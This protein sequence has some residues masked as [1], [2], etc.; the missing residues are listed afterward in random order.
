M[1]KKVKADRISASEESVF[2]LRSLNFPTEAFREV[3]RLVPVLFFGASAERSIFFVCTDFALP[4]LKMAPQAVTAASVLVLAVNSLPSAGFLLKSGSPLTEKPQSSAVP[5]TARGVFS[6]PSTGFN[7]LGNMIG[8]SGRRLVNL[9]T[10]NLGVS[11]PESEDLIGEELVTDDMSASLLS[12]RCMSEL[13]RLIKSEDGWQSE[14]LEGCVVETKK[15][16]GAYGLS[17][18]DIVRGVGEIDA[19]ADDFFEYQVSREGFQCIDEYLVNHRK[20]DQYKWLTRPELESG[21]DY[22]L[23]MNRVE[24]RYP[25]KSREFVALDTVHRPERVLISKSALHPERPGGSR[26]QDALEVD[27]PGSPFVRAVQYYGS[28]VEPVGPNKCL[29]YMVTW[30][31]M[32]DNYSAW[33]VNQFNKYLF[34]TPKFRRFREAMSGKTVWEES[35]IV[36]N[37]WDILKLKHNMGGLKPDRTILKNGADFGKSRTRSESVPVPELSEQR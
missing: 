37:A 19:S 10:T 6:L 34:I 35:N 4:S 3:G 33:W 2:T 26:Y 18:V 25:F 32:C 29:L 5:V 20:V 16:H 7:P 14:E 1:L 31:E 13:D 17:G 15:T 23:M 8:G 27:P 11:L 9:E 24:W 28:K 21:K 30:G 12:D 36:N 22:E